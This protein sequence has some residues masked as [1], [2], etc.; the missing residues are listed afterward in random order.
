MALRIDS[1]CHAQFC[2]ADLLKGKGLQGGRGRFGQ[3]KAPVEYRQL[4]SAGGR[5]SVIGLSTNRFGAATVPQAEVTAR[6]NA[7]R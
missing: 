2:G 3:R 1:P 7:M 4:G 5:V 6:D